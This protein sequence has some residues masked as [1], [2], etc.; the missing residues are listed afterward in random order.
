MGKRTKEQER[1]RS[2]RRRSRERSLQRTLKN[3]TIDDEDIL[4]KALAD[5]GIH[6][7]LSLEF[8]VVE[9]LRRTCSEYKLRQA[10][11]ALEELNGIGN[12]RTGILLRL[13][14]AD[15]HPNVKNPMEQEHYNEYG[16]WDMEA[17]NKL[18]PE[19]QEAY[20]EEIDERRHEAISAHIEAEQRAQLETWFNRD[21][22]YHTGE[23]RRVKP[24]PSLGQLEEREGVR[25]PVPPK[26]NKEPQE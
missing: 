3:I 22:G 6:V 16:F 10:D 20:W 25:A 26:D 5:E 17:W 13:E 14:S 24:K 19:Q 23:R 21:T 2:Q 4:R 11:K 18:S 9:K 1:Q 8:A 15:E 12:A 7:S